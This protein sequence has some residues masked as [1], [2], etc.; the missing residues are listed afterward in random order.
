VTYPCKNNTP[1][2]TAEIVYTIYSPIATVVIKD[3]AGI[4]L[5]PIE[6]FVILCFSIK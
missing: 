2:I 1:K 5:K 3:V 4:S 6:D